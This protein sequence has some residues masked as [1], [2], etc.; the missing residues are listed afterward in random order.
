MGGQVQYSD[1]LLLLT[2]AGVDKKEEIRRGRKQNGDAKIF[3]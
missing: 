2:L 3:Q 1:V